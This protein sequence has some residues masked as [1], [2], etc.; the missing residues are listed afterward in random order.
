MS[1]LAQYQKEVEDQYDRLLGALQGGTAN[2]LELA[3]SRL[4]HERMDAELKKSPN[5]VI[6]RWDFK[7]GQEKTPS[8][9]PTLWLFDWRKRAEQELHPFTPTEADI[10]AKENEY[11]TAFIKRIKDL[12]IKT[13]TGGHCDVSYFIEDNPYV[14]QVKDAFRKALTDWMQ[15]QCYDPT[16]Y[17]RSAIVGM[18]TVLEQRQ[19][20]VIALRAAQDMG[21]GVTATPINIP[22]WMEAL[23]IGVSCVPGMGEFIALTEAASGRD[24]FCRKL[25]LH[26]RVLILGLILIPPIMKVAR[27][28]KAIYTAERMATLYGRDAAKWSRMISMGER[29]TAHPTVRRAV[30]QAA[31]RVRAQQALDAQAIKDAEQALAVLIGKAPAPAVPALTGAQKKLLQALKTLGASKAQLAELDEIALSR[32]VDAARTKNGLDVA[33]GKGQLLEEI[34][35][36]RTVKLLREQFAKQA[37]GIQGAGVAEHFS[38][39]MLRDSAGRKITDGIIGTRLPKSQIKAQWYGQ[40]TS[41]EIENIRGVIQPFAI[42][43]AKAGRASAQGLGYKYNVTEADIAALKAVALKRFEKLKAAATKEGKAFAETLEQVEKEVANEYK[44]GEIGG[45]AR[46]DIERLDMNADG[47]LPSIFFGDEQFL[48]Y[49]PGVSKVKI[50]GVVPKSVSGKGLT[51]RLRAQGINFEVLG[52][53]ITAQELEDLAKEVLNLAK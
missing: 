33:L 44:L 34:K 27:A 25:S 35:E 16:F 42:D 46:G 24:T 52:I 21:G 36:T 22:I 17:Q 30:V 51:R 26:E 1:T 6:A 39:H 18:A 45:Q 11:R 9:G 15:T 32:V 10:L 5:E 20:I 49:I 3:V 2:A 4:A 12:N 41:Q 47:S 31:E 48:V 7:A 23:G 43:E 38:G 28:G 19:D 53:N 37:L 50:F 14:N 40:R 29:A 8:S 13:H